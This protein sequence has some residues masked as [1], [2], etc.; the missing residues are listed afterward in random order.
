MGFLHGQRPPIPEGVG[1]S[2][3]AGRQRTLGTRSREEE[4]WNVQLSHHLSS[5]PSCGRGGSDRD[6][7]E[8]GRGEARGP[9]AGAFSLNLR[10]L[11]TQH[12]KEGTGGGSWIHLGMLRRGPSPVS[13]GAEFCTA[14]P[15]PRHCQMRHLKA[16]TMTL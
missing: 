16:L 4:L 8:S 1:L 11:W 6:W 3:P 5:T 10:F 2:S 15:C 13:T 9:P 7:S 12:L 14:L